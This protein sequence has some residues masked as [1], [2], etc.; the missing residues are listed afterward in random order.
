MKIKILA[1]VMLLLALEACNKSAADTV[2]PQNPSTNKSLTLVSYGSCSELE[3]EIKTMLTGEMERNL[4]GMKYN[5]RFNGDNWGGGDPLMQPT[6]SENGPAPTT[7]TNLQEDGVDEAD[8]IKTDGR[9]AYAIVGGEV[10]IAKVWPFAEFGPVA[11]IKPQATPTGIYLSE[12]KLIVLSGSGNDYG[13]IPLGCMSAAGAPSKCVIPPEEQMQTIEEVYD[14]SNPSSPSLLK[15]RVFNAN[16][17]ASRRVGGRLYLILTSDGVKYPVFDY[18]TGIDYMDLPVCPES[19]EPEPNDQMVSA[20]EKLKEKNR[21]MVNSLTLAELVPSVGEGKEIGCTEVMRSEA[22]VGTQFLIISSDPYADAT[23]APSRS[24]ILS[25]GGTVY[26]SKNALYVS[27]TKMPSGWWG[28]VVPMTSDYE[29]TDSTV[30]HRFAID[31]GAPVYN[32]SGEID[33]HLLDNGFAGSQYSI[34][35]SMAQFAM[36][37]DEGYLRVATTKSTFGEGNVTTDNRVV[38]LDTTTLSKVGE[39]GG[40]GSG[41]K[42]HAVRFIGKKGYVVTFKKTDPLYVVDL[43]DPAAPKVAGELKVP[44][45]STYLHPYDDGHLIGLGFA[46]DDMGGFAWTQGLKLAL[47]DVTDPAAPAEV[48]T[49]E[50][51]SRGS[52]SPAVE[53]HHAFTFDKTRGL[54]ALPVTIYEGGEGGNDRGDYSWGGV[55]LLKADLSGTFDTVGQIVLD[56]TSDDIWFH[57]PASGFRTVIIGDG[58]DNGILTLT[59]FGVQLNRID[60]TM[61]R[62]GEI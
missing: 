58:K 53:E 16:M 1:V 13:P 24:V 33:G 7:K 27:A 14:V 44:G 5:C 21:T 48:G 10:R 36:S 25:N 11:T 57:F 42:I 40:M 47:F 49:R 17:L 30:I 20:I 38:V 8:L 56:E 46:A 18:D 6:A 2:T 34:R 54:L 23:A 59:E 62:I 26:S 39:V 28:P 12:G 9:Y 37:E 32:A 43:T 19:G 4:D 55:M 52:Y 15:S 31:S 51:G 60:E 50:I 35:F 45:F 29:F 22:A 41:E 3:S 61:T